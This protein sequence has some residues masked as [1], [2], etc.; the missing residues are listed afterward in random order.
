MELKVKGVTHLGRAMTDRNLFDEGKK[1]DFLE[2]MEKLDKR[3]TL[4][5]MWP[6]KELKR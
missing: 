4:L 5:M 1:A 6:V 3:T 2:R